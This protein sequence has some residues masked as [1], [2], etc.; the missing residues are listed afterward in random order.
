MISVWV[1]VVGDDCDQFM[2]RLDE[3]YIDG[4]PPA[5]SDPEWLTHYMVEWSGIMLRSGQ[6]FSELGVPEGHTLN[7][8]VVLCHHDSILTRG[9]E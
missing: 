5:I 1:E 8:Y 7:L 2:Q 3:G 6:K 4:F 9:T